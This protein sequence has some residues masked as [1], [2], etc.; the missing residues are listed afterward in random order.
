MPWVHNKG[1]DQH[2]HPYIRISAFLICS[3]GYFADR[4]IQPHKMARGLT[5]KKL[6]DCSID[7]MKT[8]AQISCGSR[9]ADLRLRFRICKNKFL[10]ALL[11]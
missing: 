11:I 5:F 2:A 1:A 10:M 7:V 3:N 8:K 9:E 6:R 4:A